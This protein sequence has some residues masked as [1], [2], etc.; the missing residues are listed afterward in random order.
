MSEPG[1]RREPRRT[2][3][4]IVTVEEATSSDAPRKRTFGDLLFGRRLASAEE[5]EHKIGTLAGIPVLG[6]DALS[7]AAYGPEAALMLLLPLGAMGL[8]YVVPITGIII[9]VLLIVYFS[10]RQTIAAYPNG[11]GSYTVAKDNLGQGS[12]LLAGAA[13]ALDY[14]LNVAVGISAGVGALVSA[15]PS[16]LPHTLPICLVIL[17][18]LTVV[19]LR[20]TRESGLTFLLP[21]YLFVATLA[22]VIVIGAAKVA[23]AGGHPVPVAATPVL[24]ISEKAVTFWLLMRAFASGCT[25]MTGVEAVSNGVPVFRAPTIRNAERTLTV[26]IAILVVLLAGIALLSRAYGIGATDPT[27]DGY[28]SVLS[29]LTMAVAGR[30]A[31][32]YVTMGSV[33]TVL[34]LSA[35]TSFADFPRL[36]RVLALD[37]FLPDTF[38]LRGRRLVF[39]YGVIV[40]AL[41]SGGLL[42]LFGGI[43]DNLIPLFAIGAFLAFTLSQAGMVQHW[44]KLFAAGKGQGSRHSM[45]I[46]GVGAVA[47]GVTLVV[48][49][50]SKFA[51]GAWIAVLAVP[52]VVLMF[53]GIKRH[54][55]SVA[56]QVADDQPLVLTETQP[57]I[58]VVPVQSWSQLTSRGLRFALELS[59]DVRALHILTQDST[60]SELTVVWEDLVAGPA[61]AAGLPPPQL[62][63]RKSTYRQFF[64]PLVEFVEQLRDR[65]PDRDVVVIVPDLVVKRWYHT[66]LHNN[67]GTMLRGL[68]RLRGGPRVVVVNTPFYLKE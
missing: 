28:Q 50:V 29:Q 68:L 41:L 5:E 23:L 36:C 9:T 55:A 46:N 37:R 32:Y 58:V 45:W 20:G 43:T 27:K 67:R 6:L 60:I 1:S 40:L 56:L 30:G 17:A 10:Y 22:V 31:F 61:R 59:P 38:A 24:P 54:Y 4:Q 63:L 44:R 53:S 15:A 8:G 16:L 3:P 34:A 57:P 26:I 21:T 49:V 19:N 18:L 14:V 25:A 13:L 51:E 7:S 11:G 35:N 47:T 52:L 65:H 42:V 12:A 64:A 33:V 66:L 2:Y 48:V 39:S 62:I